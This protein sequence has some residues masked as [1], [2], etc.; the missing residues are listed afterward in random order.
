MLCFSVLLKA[1]SH[2]KLH[3]CGAPGHNAPDNTPRMPAVAPSS[4]HLVQPGGLVF[5]PWF[6]LAWDAVQLGFEA[7]SVIALRLVRLATGGATAWTE[8]R[9]M[10]SEKAAASVE[11]HVATM[12][13]TLKGQESALAAEKIL[14]IYKKR[15]RA[16][17]RRL[18]R[19]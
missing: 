11:T 8:A 19:R 14:R 6:L 18:S 13:G 10:V 7:Q 12:G 15:V 3:C 9:R 1:P 5:N 17:K 2:E 16:N 4:H